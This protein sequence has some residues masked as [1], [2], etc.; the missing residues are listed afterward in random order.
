MIA[1]PYQLYVE[2]KGR[3][4]NM[5]RFYSMSVEVNLFGEIYLTRRRGRIGAKGQTFAS[6]NVAIPKD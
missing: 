4:K 3:A 2:C 1:Q 5:T 6:L